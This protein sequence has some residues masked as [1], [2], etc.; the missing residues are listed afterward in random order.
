MKFNI[1]PDCKKAAKDLRKQGNPA[2]HPVLIGNNTRSLKFFLKTTNSLAK[3]SIRI[4]MHILNLRENYS[5]SK[6]TALRIKTE[7]M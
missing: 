6:Y 4:S 7:I 2:H 3:K 1:Y 5:L